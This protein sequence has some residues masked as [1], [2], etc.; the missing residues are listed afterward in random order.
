MRLQKYTHIIGI[1]ESGR[2]PLAGPVVLGAVCVSRENMHRLRRRFR[3]ICDPKRMTP[4]QREKWFTILKKV[5]GEGI[6]SVSV[7]FSSHTV[8]DKYGIVPAVRFALGRHCLLKAQRGFFILNLPRWLWYTHGIMRSPFIRL[9][10][11]SHYSLL[12]GLSKIPEMVKLAKKYEMPALGLTDHGVMYGAVEFYKACKKSGIKPIIGLEA[13]VANNTRHDKRAGVDNRR[14]HLTLLAKNLTGY[15]NLIQLVSKAHLEGFYYKP[16]VD[17]EL[18]REHGDGL[19]CLSGCMAGELSRA[20]ANNP[21]TS[22]GQ[23]NQEK[24]KEIIAEH[25]DIFGKENYYLEVMHHPGVE[26][27]SEIRDAV[28]KLSKETG[29]LLVATQDSHYLHKEDTRAHETLLAVQQGT[30]VDNVKR[31]SFASDDFSFIDTPTAYEYFA[32]I[33]EAVENTSKIAEQC[34]IQLELGSWV[35]PYFKIPE[36]TTH[37]SELRRLAY[38]G[39]P[40]R[41]LQETSEVKERIEYEL[42]II[43]SKGYSPYFLVVGDLLRFARENNILTNTRG[44]AAGSLVSYLLGIT[45]VD[46]LRLKLPFERFL[47]PERPSAPDIDMDF[48]DNRRDEVIDYARQKYGND[49]VAQIGT[50]GTM[51]ARGAV[52]DVARAL[53]HPYELGDKIAKQI[54]FGSQGFPMTIDRAFEIVSDL[55]DMHE[56][57]EASRDVL[58][59]ARRLEGTVRHISV[60]AAGVVIAPRPVTDYAPV[61]FD[62]GGER[63]IT[64]YD[65]HA[66]EDVG[67]LKFDFLGIKNLTILHNAEKLVRKYCGA[68]IDLEHLPL[69]DKKTYD[70]LARGETHGL[71]QLN[72]DGMTHYLM[73]LRP[74]RIED[75]NAM[76]ALY[77]PGP[78][79]FIPDY[80]KRKRNPELVT[81]LDERLKKILEPTYGILIY[82]DDILL[83]VTELAGYS[84]GEADKFRKAVGKKIP[85]EMQ[86]QKEKFMEGCIKNGLSEQKTKQL[87]GMIETFAAYGF[88]KAHSA[89]YGNVAYQTSYMKANYPTEYM[90]AVLTADAE[91]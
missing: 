56:K 15:K 86:A 37:D 58:D 77:R 52:R 79:A 68:D 57:D 91:I 3:G 40:F 26:G 24:A 53:G 9:H 43:Q 30:D 90:T 34:D 13:Y 50:F 27:Y 71:F 55:K 14:F 10:T 87:W 16:R 36:G 49:H 1:D 4:R 83:I 82:Q 29:A 74:E 48:A 28:I 59:L 7:S 38:E 45:N 69:N 67:L 51:M 54:P 84:W 60:H 2:G 78:I 5:E 89:S 6:V 17:K 20:L 64:Q 72:G 88:N 75:I 63:I 61:Q 65:M 80:I 70:M 44:S 23:A 18:L 66:V 25:Q 32:D 31:L 12:D 33:P 76:I 73:E 85:A 21:S 62:P 81:Y 41:G 35:F 42:G 22:S 39:I 47:N 46:P 8:I 11:H 19:I